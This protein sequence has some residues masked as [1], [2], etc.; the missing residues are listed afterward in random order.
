MN[1][2]SMAYYLK[3]IKDS[4]WTETNQ[5][6]EMV[7]IKSEPKSQKTIQEKLELKKQAKDK[8]ISNVPGN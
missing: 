1:D 8:L 4:F 3:Q 6:G 7:L 2:D 5:K